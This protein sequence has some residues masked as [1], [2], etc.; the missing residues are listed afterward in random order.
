M[1]DCH[2]LFLGFNNSITLKGE[3]KDS[4][5]KSKNS[6]HSKIKKYKKTKPKEIQP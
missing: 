2:N 6:L 4:L 3:R 5:R 1:A